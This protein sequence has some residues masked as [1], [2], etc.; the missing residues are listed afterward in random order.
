MA[1]HPAKPVSSDASACVARPPAGAGPDIV[2]KEIIRGKLLAVADEMGLVLK[3]SSMSPVIYETLDFACGLCTADG[4]LVAQ[5]NGITVFTGMFAAQIAVVT[6]KFGDTLAAGDVFIVNDPYVAGTHFNDIGLIRPIF[7]EDALFAFAVSISHWTDIGGMAPGSMP[8]DSTEIFQEGVCFPCVRLFK[9]GE[10]QEAIFDIIKAN[11]RMPTEA[12]GDLNAALAA[13]RIAEGRVAELTDKYGPDAIAA[14]FG[15][16]LESSERLS[17]AAVA[18]LPDGVYT[19]EDWIDGDGITEDRFPTRV[20]VTIAGDRMTVNFTGTSPQ[21]AGPVNCCRGALVSAVKTIF[22]AVVDPSAPSNE[23]WFRPLEIIA[24]DG[25][26]FT[27]MKPAPVSWYFEGTGQASELVWKALAPVVPDRVSMGSANSLCVTVL[28]GSDDGN[29][30]P[31]V[32]IEPNMVGWGATDERDGNC[33]TSAITDGDTFNY[34][35]ELLEAMFPVRV[36]QYALNTEGGVG[37]GQ[38]R[39]GYGAVKD[40]EVLV[41][42]TILSASLGRSVERPWGGQD[43]EAGSCNHLDLHANGDVTRMART[44]TT[45]VRRGEMIRVF[46][47]GG[48]GFGNPLTRDVEAVA[49][50]VRAGYITADQAR[51]S[52]GVVMASD[53]RSCD[54]AATDTLRADRSTQRS[55]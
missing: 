14:T 32:M 10:A 42:N 17:R 3:R 40:Y 53:G 18:A 9:A 44:P 43:G 15:H 45:T 46:T 48:G 19:A 8:A 47:G 22:K 11:T 6:E 28:G 51:D 26:V 13:L 52:Y 1:V 54:R 41:D 39:G 33:V 49:E 24:P 50:E 29:G 37:A 20:Q 36:H 2:T 31:W 35:V 7:V 12:M 5:M 27:A 55:A 38:K 25:T 23:G 30:E 21:A 16:I 4:E 34:S